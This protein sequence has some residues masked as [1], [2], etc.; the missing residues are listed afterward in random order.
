MCHMRPKCFLCYQNIN[1]TY[2]HL[3]LWFMLRTHFPNMTQHAS[4]DR[5]TEHTQYN[6]SYACLSDARLPMCAAHVCKS[7]CRSR[8]DL[9]QQHLFYYASFA[10]VF[11]FPSRL[12]YLRHQNHMLFSA[13]IT[14]AWSRMHEKIC[15]AMICD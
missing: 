2:E 1:I 8:S 9:M 7:V 5:T 15:F 6:F 3:Q 12:C 4:A 11:C 14:G 10:H 13:F